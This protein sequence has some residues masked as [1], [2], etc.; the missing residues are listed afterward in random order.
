MRTSLL[1]LLLFISWC[2]DVHAQITVVNKKGTVIDVD[3]SKWKLSDTNIYNKNPG[4]VG[5]GTNG[6]PNSSAALE[7]K[8]TN[9]GLLIP[10]VALTG[11]VPAAPLAAHVA[12]MM[13][14]NT[15][16]A[17]AAPDNVS[18]GFYY[19]NGAK[20]V[21]VSA[22]IQAD[23][24]NDGW[25]EE[26]ANTQ[27]KL[28]YLSDG[29]TAR[30]DS[31]AFVIKDNGRVGL[32]LINPAG[33]LDV[34]G[35]IYQNNIQTVYNAGAIGTPN[36]AGS[37]FL[38]NGGGGL[39]T[40]AIR[41]TGIGTNALTANTS[42]TNNTAIG[43]NAM[44]ATTTGI[45]NTATGSG[46]LAGN[47]QGARNTAGGAFSLAG[48]TLGTDNTALGA[49]S[50]Q[51]NTTGINN[52]AIGLRALAS[53]TGTSNGV[54]VG[55]E[56]Q[57][58][59][60]V[61]DVLLTNS[62]TSVGYQS[63]KGSSTP[64]SNIGN[65]NTAIGYQAMTAYTSANYNVAVGYSAM[66]GTIDG[67]MNTAVGSYSLEKNTSGSYNTAIGRYA[68]GSSTTSSYNT[69]LGYNAGFDLTTSASGINTFIGYNTGRGITTGAYNTVLGANV[70][71]LTASLNNNIILAD[72]QGNQRIR[73]LDNGNTGIGT[74]SPTARLDVMPAATSA[75]GLR[76]QNMSNSKDKQDGNIA[77][78]AP[79]SSPL[80]IDSGGYVYKKYN[81]VLSDVDAQSFDG[82]YSMGSGPGGAATIVALNNGSIVRFQL[83]LGALLLG[84][85]GVGANL[86]A[87]V[88]YSY[89]GSGFRVATFASETG[90]AFTNALTVTGIGTNTLTFDFASG[91]DVVITNTS[92]TQ[93]GPVA[94]YHTGTGTI[95]IEIFQ[96]FRS[97]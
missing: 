53:S 29:T 89:G 76:V 93:S 12:G 94:I 25:K 84:G 92:G 58:N 79:N 65:N 23:T 51:A 83:F 96:S 60:V 20:W 48:N 67:V 33:R 54:A 88:T 17:G 21:K 91:V 70:T 34:N 8:A 56:S 49:Y 86:Y 1:L 15:A 40:T 47:T 78:T 68:L 11:T 9:K 31:A 63:L 97:R 69:A 44:N 81:P 6:A 80:Y 50:L 59:V 45:F 39:A 85:A 62:N 55:Y 95:P 61:P 72:G 42:G 52:V 66:L 38:G 13:V 75:S 43:F 87:D 71:G 73:V 28:S 41:N 27:V 3:S 10:R 2:T 7:V 19:S 14:Y 46:A 30:P 32:G 77:Y 5:I 16:T 74:T 4:N 36:Y 24:T 22:V 82:T 37:L 90:G 35:K 18:P 64:A 57:G 26:P